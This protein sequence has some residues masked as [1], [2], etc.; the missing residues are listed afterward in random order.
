MQIHISGKG[1]EVEESLRL[2][3]QGRA[4]ESIAKYIDRV[5]SLEVVVSKESHQFRVDMHGNIGTHAGLVIRSHDKSDDMRSAADGALQRIEK[6]LRR[7]KR[8]L[9]DHHK[10]S[11]GGAEQNYDVSD[12]R[13]YVLPGDVGE[14]DEDT[15]PLSGAVIAEK[16]TA[17]ENLTVSQAVMKMDLQDLPALMFTNRSN[18]QLNVVY[19]RADGNIAWV[20]PEVKAA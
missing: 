2:Y 13:K 15:T 9:S 16:S 19:R 11:F 12:A 18:G 10:I 8:K 7:Y 14:H 5:N 6:Q 20:D 4:E 1:T 17:L 3:I